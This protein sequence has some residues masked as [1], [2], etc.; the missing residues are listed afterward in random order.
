MVTE[1]TTEVMT[2]LV[3]LKLAL[4]LTFVLPCGMLTQ[5]FMKLVTEVTLDFSH[6]FE[7]PLL[8]MNLTSKGLDIFFPSRTN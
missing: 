5:H 3:A 7:S 4:A 1:V 6:R 8:P 2:G